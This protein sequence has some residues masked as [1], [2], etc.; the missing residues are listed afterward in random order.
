MKNLTQFK[1]LFHSTSFD[2][3]VKETDIVI[4]E[5]K[6]FMP[7]TFRLRFCRLKPMM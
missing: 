3:T 6:T 5:G 4:G 2:W 1:S 7:L